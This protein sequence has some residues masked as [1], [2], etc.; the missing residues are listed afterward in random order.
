MEKEF[1]VG[2]VKRGEASTLE[3]FG[4]DLQGRVGTRANVEVKTGTKTKY[5]LRRMT[6][7]DLVKRG[8][9]AYSSVSI[10]LDKAFHQFGLEKK[11]AGVDRAVVAGGPRARERMEQQI[12][13]VAKKCCRN[14]ALSAVEDPNVSWLGGGEIWG[15]ERLKKL[16]ET[17]GMDRYPMSE[18]P[19]PG[20]VLVVQGP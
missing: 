5:V 19:D 16:P 12:V 8:L 4:I 14:N 7:Q 3:D 6:R 15:K 10:S 18:A 20:L 2:P 1:E 13:A 17:V 9:S 11:T